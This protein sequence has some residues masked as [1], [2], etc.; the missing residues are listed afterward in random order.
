MATLEDLKGVL[1]SI[2]KSIIEQKDLL[3]NMFSI[4]E[5][6]NRLA[7]V[8]TNIA[9][10]GDTAGTTQTVGQTIAQSAAPGVG[11]GLGAAAAGAGGLIGLGAGIAGFMAALSIG[12]IG[13]DWL[14]NDYSGLGDAFASFS[15]AME[16]LS[17]A[18]IA[19]LAGASAIAA[20]TAS[21]KNL[22]GLGTASGMV[23]LG[24]GISGFLIGLALGE[25]GLGWVGNDYS[26]I[27]GALASF[28]DA[29]GNLSAEAV[30]LLGGIA[31]IAIANTAFGG[32]P[33]SL[34]ANMTVLAAGIAGFLGGLVLTDIGLS[35]ITSVS[36]ADGSGL[37]SAFKLFNDS[38]GEL[39]DPIAITAL[40][41]ILAAGTAAGIAK[42]SG[43]VGV[44]IGIASIMTGIGAGIA[45]LM[46]GLVGSGIAIDWID[47]ASGLDSGTLVGAFKLFNDSV[48]ALND[49][50]A[51]IALGAI[52]AAGTAAG[53]ATNV[54]GVGA[55][56]G[57]TAV[58]TGI[59]AGIAGLMIGLVGGG[60]AIDWINKAS[61]LDSGALVGAFK[62]FND[63]VGALNNENA[64]KALGAILAV[65]T[66]AG[67]ATNVGGVG[68]GIGIAA[69]MNGIGAG[70]AG[71][72]IGLATGGKIVDLI[73]SIPGGDGDGLVSVFKMFNDTVLAIT[74]AAIERLKDI[75]TLGGLNIGDALKQL[76]AGAL[77]MFGAGGLTS[78]GSM[79][80]DGLKNTVDYIFGTDYAS[81][82]K[83]SIFQ[84]LVDGLEPIKDFDVAPINA[85]VNTLDTLTAAFERLANIDAGD[86]IQKNI[87]GMMKN[88]GGVMGIMPFLL[89]GGYYRGESLGYGDN[90]DFGP[91]GEG[92]LL[93]LR[94]EDLD[95]LK[96]QISKLYGA[97]DIPSANIQGGD[98][99]T[100]SPTGA[101]NA[102]LT[103]SVAAAV[104]E[105]QL[106]SITAENVRVETETA[107]INKFQAQAELVKSYD[108]DKRSQVNA[109]D[110]SNKTDAR[111][112]IGGTTHSNTTIIQPSSSKNDL[113]YYFAH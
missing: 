54:G 31:A 68:A 22:Y 12:S 21:F 46:L 95:L 91:E 93:A 19:A 89:R 97:L 101:V 27:G 45:G 69:V 28:S 61:G 108:M 80:T 52:L 51:I 8:D 42:G 35:W 84:Q 81:E 110:A 59:G 71:L 102:R 33:K 112:Y 41:A 75:S 38:I 7:S 4:Q 109:I 20:G 100:P 32:N 25:I 83:P 98:V 60:I 23:G 24:A 79:I 99:A 57:I 44:G 48:G 36:G 86:G 3:T 14:G 106:V 39:K 55:G 50:N 92:G 13:L 1:E 103:E 2:D 62:I 65:G 66:A 10:S 70:I 94:D 58:M 74:P 49:E 47:K 113:D 5:T 40:G 82:A 107:T 78:I 104:A 64:I 18:A 63:S 111:Q 37:K 30:G 67:L 43:G 56:I 9:P 16:N 6:K 85:F 73:E 15:E 53:L 87:F 17:P 11:S 88:I 90:I 26:S 34:A 76:S 77:A 96:Q 29:I 72:F 105:S